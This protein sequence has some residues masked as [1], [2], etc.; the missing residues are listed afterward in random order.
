MSRNRSPLTLGEKL[1]IIEEA[2]KR[3][4]ATKASIA[5]E[6]NIPESSLK[7]ILA[8]KDSILANASKFGLKRKAA[9]EGKYV[10]MEKVLVEWLRQA[11]SSGIAVDG[12]TL[13]E[14]AESI[15][16]RCRID[17]FKASDG[18]L[19]RFKKRNGVVY[20]RCC[21]ERASVS[22]PTV[23][24]STASRPVIRHYKPSDVFSAGETGVFYNM[25]P[26]QTLLFKGESCHGGERSED[27]LTVLLCTNE[28]GSEKLPPLV[29]GKFEKPR[30]FENLKGLPCQYKSNR[31]AW[32]T[33]AIFLEFLQLLDSRMGAG[34][35]KILLLLDNAPCHPSDTAHLRNVQVAFLPPNCTEQLQP[36]DAGI[37]KC[38]KQEYRKFLVQRRLARRE[39]DQLDGKL[40]LL[41]AMHYIASAWDAVSSDT[42][43]SSFRRCGFERSDEARC[44][45]EA[46]VSID[47]EPDFDALRLPG[48]FADYVS[49]DDG[50]A[51]CGPGSLDDV[52]EA[53]LPDCTETFG[54]EEE[55]DDVAGASASVP[56]YADVLCYVDNIRRFACAHDG[57]GDL[58]PVVAALE[59]KL[60]RRGW[61]NVQKK[62][63]DFFQR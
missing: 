61:A 63:A 15:A 3:K 12:A 23:E 4:G 9:K 2:E 51:V 47:D 18:W 33:A 48:T 19:D 42:I 58:L 26:E 40:S 41:D 52:I 49:A 27:R 25:Q 6:F 21:G 39:R 54:E 5:R 17:D 55:M 53:V 35:R 24:E 43:A 14:K 57:V 16:L 62:N 60:M 13:K 22:L 11:R 36:L 59:R 30:C 29:I 8:K 28:D 37:V 56:T 46:V 7:T 45:D 50:V 44:A 1:R 32:M 38:L 34:N 20:S 10:D 31:K